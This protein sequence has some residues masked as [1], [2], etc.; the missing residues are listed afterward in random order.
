MNTHIHL[1]LSLTHTQH[2]I[3][4][5]GWVMLGHAF[6]PSTQKEP[7]GRSL[8]LRPAWP[9]EKVLRRTARDTQ[10]NPVWKNKSK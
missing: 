4:K 2:K 6:N 1:S 5:I 3:S 8:S 9:A 7:Q 10:R